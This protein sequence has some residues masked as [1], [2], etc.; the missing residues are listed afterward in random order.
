MPEY[1]VSIEVSAPA[2]RVF[3]A[4]SDLTLHSKW[5]ADPLEIEPID[6]TPIGPGKAYRSRAISK[7]KRIAAEITVTQCTRPTLFEFTASDLTGIYVHQF[8]LGESG[9]GT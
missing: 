8:Q 6:A 9:S 2:E 3:A 7:G 1:S 5:S 4:V